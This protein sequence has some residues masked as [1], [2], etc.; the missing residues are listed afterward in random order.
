MT[1]YVHNGTFPVLKGH[2]VSFETYWLPNASDADDVRL[3]YG[4]DPEYWAS[5][6]ISGQTWTSH[7]SSH[8]VGK[9]TMLA[10]YQGKNGTHRLPHTHPTPLTGFLRTDSTPSLETSRPP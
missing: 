8:I 7:I 10:I 6:S 9:S 5:S 3:Y 2:D 4:N 1:V